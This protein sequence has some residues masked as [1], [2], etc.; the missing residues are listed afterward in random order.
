MGTKLWMGKKR[1]RRLANSVEVLWRPTYLKQNRNQINLKHKVIL[2]RRVAFEP[3]FAQMSPQWQQNG[4]KVY[5]QKKKKKIA[6]LMKNLL[7][8]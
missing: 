8:H 5:S 2:K 7:A 3:N 6:R 4:G 1:G